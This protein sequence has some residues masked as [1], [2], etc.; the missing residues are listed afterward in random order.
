MAE[1]TRTHIS[2]AITASGAPLAALYDHQ[3]QH[4]PDFVKQLR[5]RAETDRLISNHSA[6]V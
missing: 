4:A 2:D 6:N 5:T 1:L 3:R